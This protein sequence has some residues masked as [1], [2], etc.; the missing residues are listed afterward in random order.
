MSTDIKLT[1][2][3]I[4]KITQSKGFFGSWLGKLGKKAL[5]NVAI[6]FLSFPNLPELASNIAFNEINTFEIK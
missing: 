5:T 2:A 4:S 6:P 1:K 3:Q